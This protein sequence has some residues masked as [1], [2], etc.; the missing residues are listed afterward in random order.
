ML[1]SKY[2]QLVL[3]L[4]TCILIQINYA[5]AKVTFS[6]STNKPVSYPLTELHFYPDFDHRRYEGIALVWKFPGY[7]EPNTECFFPPVN[8]SDPA[9]QNIAKSAF[10][11]PDF[12]LI[13]NDIAV[14]RNVCDTKEQI[15]KAMNNLIWQLSHA[16]FPS[17]KLVIL[18]SDLPQGFFVNHNYI[19]LFSA[20]VYSGYGELKSIKT[21]V[22]KIPESLFNNTI[23]KDHTSLHYI[24]ELEPDP[25]N[26]LL[27]SH[28]HIAYKWTYFTLVL[29]VLLYACARIINWQD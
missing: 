19:T 18:S 5:C 7:K 11:Y 14:L 26:E 6:D 29:G 27:F 21:A 2:Q 17:V 22:L 16:G 4:F 1:F 8:A 9:I 15:G 10:K 25:W 23:I 12:A 20:N 13:V 3:L 28:T 24:A